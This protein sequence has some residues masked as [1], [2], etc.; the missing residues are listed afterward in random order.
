MDELNTKI[1][2]NLRRLRKDRGLSLDKVAEITGVSKAM[3]GQI[4]R[5]ESNPTVSTLWKIA[6]G[7]HVSFTSF[8]ED[9]VPAVSIVP[10][11]KIHPFIE[12]SGRYKV[13]PIFPFDSSK[14]FELYAIDI[15]V[16]CSHKSESHQEGVEEYILVSEGILK[17]ELEGELYSIKK[18]DGIRFRADRP[19]VYHNESSYLTR[20]HL[21]IYYPD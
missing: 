8:I 11:E 18:G 9:Q 4:E 10:Y 6:N 14:R 2:K 20:I 21:L 1:G 7:L 3:L 5:G 15:E 17:L 13:Y 16:G 12:D 19:H